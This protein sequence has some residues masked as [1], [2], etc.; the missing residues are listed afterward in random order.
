MEI[1]FDRQKL[2]D[3]FTM[4]S[5]VASSKSPN[6]VLQKY[7]RFRAL[8]EKAS[9]AATDL[10]MSLEVS[11]PDVETL[12]PGECLLPIAEMGRILHENTDATMKLDC[13]GNVLNV[14]G[15]NRYQIPIPAVEDYVDVALADLQVTHETS[16][17]SLAELGRLTVFATDMESARYAMSGV[18][19]EMHGQR[20]LGVA[21]DG[22]RLA[23]VEIDARAVD[24]SVPDVQTAL[25]PRRG[26]DLLIRLLGGRDEELSIGWA[27]NMFGVDGQDFRFRTNQVEGKFPNWRDAVERIKPGAQVEMVTE[28][29]LAAVRQAA[30]V[31]DNESPGLTFHLA[32]GTLS[33]SATTQRGEANV[34]LPVSYN[35]AAVEVILDYRYVTDFLRVLDPLSVF[36]LD[37]SGPD[38]AVVFRAGE[39]Y[40]YV[41]MP[42]ARR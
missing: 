31:C 23:K 42:M 32:D 27:G 20:F 5:A 29:A 33:V 6:P 2:L 17:K 1:S 39:R 3:S 30:I 12:R 13:A 18:L 38:R 11:V 34:T 14:I 37:M 35:G 10:E 22:R 7:V 19:L 15:K 28:V 26:M 36:S 8:Q 4:A 41:L 25:V 21:T 16:A 40:M 9:I 24:A